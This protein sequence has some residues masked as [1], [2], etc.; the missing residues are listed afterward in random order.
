MADLRAK[1]RAFL[2][3]PVPPGCDGEP[4][5][6]DLVTLRVCA[7]GCLEK[8]VKSGQLPAADALILGVC[9]DQVAGL[10]SM[11]SGEAKAYFSEL[12]QLARVTL[13]ERSD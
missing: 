4:D 11:L 10:K 12:A 6:V 1:C 5:G 9:V 2:S 13:S 8:F 3:R 7:T